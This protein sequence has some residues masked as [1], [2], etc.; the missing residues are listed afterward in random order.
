MVRLQ[1][2]NEAEEESSPAHRSLDDT[3]PALIGAGEEQRGRQALG[4]LWNGNS[5]LSTQSVTS[6]KTS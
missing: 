3:W 2:W 1:L 6:A 5:L 4:E